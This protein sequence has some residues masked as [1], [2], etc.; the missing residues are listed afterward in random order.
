[1]DKFIR[2]SLLCKASTSISVNE[3]KDCYQSVEDYLTESEAE[4]SQDIRQ[5][6]I[7]LDRVVCVHFYPHTPIGFYQVYHWDVDK[8]VDEALAIAMEV[9]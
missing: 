3:H 1:M 2:L 5:Q 4:V 8:A 7:E 9:C 6:M